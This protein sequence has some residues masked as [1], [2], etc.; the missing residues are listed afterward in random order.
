MIITLELKIILQNI[1]RRVLGSVLNNISPSN[2][3]STMLLLERFHQNCLAVFGRI[4]LTLQDSCEIK[5]C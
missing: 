4:K 3:F 2:I 1:S 5:S